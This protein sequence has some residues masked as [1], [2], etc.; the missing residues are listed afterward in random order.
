METKNICLFTAHTPSSGGGGAI[1]RSLVE[2]IPG[3]KV[4]WYYTSDKP[5]QGYEAGYLGKSIIGGPFL[6]DI[7][8][9]WKM[10]NGGTVEP[11]NDL[12]KNLLDIECDAYWI[13]SHNEGLRLVCEMARMQQSKAVHMTIHDDWAGALSAR[14]IRYRF[15]AGA[16]RKLTVKAIQTVTSFDVI[17]RGMQQYYQQLSGKKGEVCH[18]YLRAEAIYEQEIT[19]HP[20]T[21]AI[22]HIGSIYKKGDLLAFINLVKEFFEPKGKK[23][24]LQMWGCHL[25]MADIPDRLKDNVQ[26]HP[27]LSEEKVISQLSKCHFVYAMYPMSKELRIFSKTSLPTKLTSYLQAG[28]PV[29][30]H[31]PADST[32]AEYL[33]TTGLGVQWNSADKAAGFKALEVLANIKIANAQ[34]QNAR[35]K[36]FGENNLAV[37]S[38][39]FL[40]KM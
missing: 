19:P 26:F 23:P 36:Y 11:L 7:K 14:S 2:D 8:Q 10:L 33:N 30:G 37:M 25:T 28:S 29:F 38:N 9:S 17:S 13:V 20:H 34:L 3:V 16:A 27:T 12:I 31:C 40:G 35:E 4:A 18:R 22:G 39:A 1:L 6:Q 15:M 32:L 5:A 21:I 24:I